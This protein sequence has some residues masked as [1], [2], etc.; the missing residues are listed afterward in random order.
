MSETA[1]Q[2]EGV[3]LSFPLTSHRPRGIKQALLDA[4]TG[5]RI[6]AE[7]KEFQALT[8]INLSVKRG[9][10]LGLIGAN[11]SGKST[12]LTT[13]CGIYQPDRGRVITNGRISALLELGAG[14]RDD[15]TGLENIQLNGAILGV[16]PDVVR[17]KTGEIVEFSGLGQFVEQPLRTYSSG[18]RARL[19]FAIAATI[20]PEILLIDEV[21][22]V[23]DEEF[24]R[25]SLAR[26][27]ELAT[28]DTT[29][30]VV[31][32]NLLLLK[33]LCRR[34]VLLSKGR[35]AEDGDPETVVAR[36]LQ[37]V[38]STA[39]TIEGAIDLAAARFRNGNGDE[40]ETVATREVLTIELEIVPQDQIPDDLVI[41]L[42]FERWQAIVTEQTSPAVPVA[43][44]AKGRAIRVAFRFDS[45]DLVPGSY[46]LVSTVHSA[47]GTKRY[48]IRGKPLVLKVVAGE[49]QAVSTKGL[50]ASRGE[51]KIALG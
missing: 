38:G 12:L 37:L 48:D 42:G 19:G 3:S 30:V 29:I 1:I 21:L 11:G 20:Q 13:I 7:R 36:Y 40:A 23:G 50:W 32:H 28:G 26:I 43:S 47:D 44:L 9:E 18:M 33:K 25:K 31:S 49:Q 6:R 17:A 22:S 4:V 15:L 45:L 24:A 14:F 2:V 8:D 51:W 41:T 27:E 34:I 39:I 16:P 46:L 5:Q 35:I 10:V